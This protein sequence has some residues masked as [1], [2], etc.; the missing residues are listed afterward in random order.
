VSHSC[1]F[2]FRLAI[3]DARFSSSLCSSMILVSSP[4]GA[5]SVSNDELK[6]TTAASC[7]LDDGVVLNGIVRFSSLQAATTTSSRLSLARWSD[8]GRSQTKR[9]EHQSQRRSSVQNALNAR[10]RK[11]KSGREL[12]KD[13]IWRF[14]SN[15]R[16][17]SAL[18]SRV[19]V[20][21]FVDRS[22][23]L[24]DNFIGARL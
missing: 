5:G 11:P 24:P 21:L 10:K 9:S 7:P 12:G 19:A 3:I 13:P 8:F 16:D 23:S 14:A 2:F 15:G 18:S 22:A 17:L 6:H 20:A 1:C 4:D